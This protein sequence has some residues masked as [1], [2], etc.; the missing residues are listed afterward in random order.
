VQKPENLPR[1]ENRKQKIIYEMEVDSKIRKIKK[2]QQ[3]QEAQV[4]K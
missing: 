1:T 4:G 2:N 3:K